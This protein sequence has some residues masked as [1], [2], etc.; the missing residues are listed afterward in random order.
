MKY[1]IDESMLQITAKSRELKIRKQRRNVGFIAGLL[2]LVFTAFVVA[3]YEYSGFGMVGTEYSNY[4]A[5]MLPNE[6]GGYILV[7]VISFAVAVIV[8]LICLRY[9]G[10]NK[11]SPKDIEKNIEN[12]VNKGE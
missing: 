12:F 9:R 6:A 4:G 8:T 5:F 1:S 7:G 11:S 2:V 10:R 3:I